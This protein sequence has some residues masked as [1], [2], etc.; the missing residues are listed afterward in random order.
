MSGTLIARHHRAHLHTNSRTVSSD[1]WRK[2]WALPYRCT[3]HV[4]SCF[5]T[6]NIARRRHDGPGLRPSTALKYRALPQTVDMGPYTAEAQNVRGPQRYDWFIFFFDLV[7]SLELSLSCSLLSLFRFS[8]SIHFYADY[9]RGSPR[10]PKQGNSYCAKH[11]K[12]QPAAQT[13]LSQQ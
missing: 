13:Y 8:A 11:H 12:S 5:G 10:S 9:R 2:P 1:Y 4:P 6:S 7:H 3:S